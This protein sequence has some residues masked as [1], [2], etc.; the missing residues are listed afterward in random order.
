VSGRRLWGWHR[1]DPYWAEQIIASAAIR[2]GELVVDL[3]AG[4]G[5]LTLPL[6]DA[7]ARVIA[8]ELHAGRMNKLRAKVGD[9]SAS[10]VRCDLEDFVAPG[11][12]F[13]LVANPPYGMTGAVLPFAARSRYLMSADLVLQRAVVRRVVVQGRRELRRFHA[14]RG[15]SLPRN[16]FVPPPNVD[17]AV[18]QLRRRRWQ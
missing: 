10:V 7:G 13:R 16:A 6:P 14:R 5:A 3:G 11:R 12:P 2:P 18:L 1:L 9:H 4:D 17:S 8:V 15:L